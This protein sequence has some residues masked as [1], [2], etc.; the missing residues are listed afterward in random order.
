[1]ATRQAKARTSEP[2]KS[3]RQ[4]EQPPTT[5]TEPLVIYSLRDYCSLPWNES[6]LPGQPPATPARDTRSTANGSHGHDIRLGVVLV[7]LECGP[8]F[9]CRS[10]VLW[11]ALSRIPEC[12]RNQTTLACQSGSSAHESRSWGLWS[13]L[14]GILRREVETIVVGVAW[15]ADSKPTGDGS[16]TDGEVFCSRRNKL[17][18]RLLSSVIAKQRGQNGCKRMRPRHVDGEMDHK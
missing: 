16:N 10:T 8:G 3:L 15:P 9:K 13:R 17:Y 5:V 4:W 2:L 14:A 1:M 6:W 18:R 7:G 11:L 12:T